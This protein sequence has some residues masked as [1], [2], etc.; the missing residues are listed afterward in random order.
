MS[1]REVPIVWEGRRARAWLPDPLVDRSWSLS[2]PTVRRTEQAVAAVRRGSDELP[3]RWEA[4]ARLL[5]RAEGT[6]SSYLE[7]VTASPAEI[8]VAE[9][10][11]MLGGAAAWVAD[12]LTA[13]SAAVAEAHRGPLTV[14]SLHRWHRALMRDA[15]NLPAHLVGGWRDAQGWVGG[16]S[17][18][19][20]ALVPPP[21]EHLAALMDD[22]VSFAN[23]SD[24]DPVTQAAMLHAQFE[25]IHPYGDGNGR[26]GRVLVGWLLTRRL[27]LVSPPPF[28]VRIAA[29]RGGY[30]SG[31]TLFRLGDVDPWVAWFAGTV[32]DAGDATV[33]LVRS[34]GELQ[35]SWRARLD[36]V[37]ADSAAR[38]LV[39]VLPQHPVLSAGT[40]ATELGISDRAGRTALETLAAR[41]VLQELGP[42]RR[43][44]GR[45]RRWW[46][47]GELVDAVSAWSRPG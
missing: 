12:N 36:G 17:P 20:A 35:G 22:L 31:L 24:V 46:V 2:E 25:L 27:G 43:A 13:V 11:P 38:R 47:A 34:V 33:R 39:D 6:A 21:P 32:A 9:L 42:S 5:L 18:L 4:L 8:A 29:D 19:D 41:G 3:T 30:L 44:A 1:G 10:D 26:I 40:V 16:T 28:S 37:R 15:G 23:R 14:E 45:P 7:G